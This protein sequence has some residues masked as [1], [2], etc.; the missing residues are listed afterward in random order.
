[1]GQQQHQTQQRQTGALFGQ[2]E[3]Q[4]MLANLGGVKL[5]GVV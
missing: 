3:V 1:M 5:R 2:D 4:V